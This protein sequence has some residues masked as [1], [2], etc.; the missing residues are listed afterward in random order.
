MENVRSRIDVRPVINEKDYLK[1]KSKPS[2]MS[3]KI[4]DVNLVAIHKNKVALT[5]NKPTC[6][7]MCILDSSKVL[8]DELYYYC[9][10]NKYD[11][12]RI[13]FTDTDHLMYETKTK[14][15]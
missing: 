1:W 10:K 2:F 8:M 11:N 13:L 6:V 3:Q 7:R 9:I 5:L 14:D 15:V 4:F 12:Y